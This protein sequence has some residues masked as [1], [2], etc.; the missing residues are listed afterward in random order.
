MFWLVTVIQPC[1]GSLAVPQAN[2]DQRM[3][4]GDAM[5]LAHWH[6][7][8]PLDEGSCQSVSAALITP[9]NTASAGAHRF[10]LSPVIALVASAAPAPRYA[11]VVIAHAPSASPLSGAPAYLRHQRL[12]I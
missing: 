10:D 9:S 3:A 1:C 11:G 2:A 8:A 7:G 4:G 5:W 12:L 6:C